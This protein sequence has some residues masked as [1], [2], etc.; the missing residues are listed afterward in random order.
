MH[1]KHFFIFFIYLFYFYF[2][3]LSIVSIPLI[4]EVST[5]IAL[6]SCGRAVAQW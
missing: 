5:Q 4:P 2:L 6:P 3:C 1:E